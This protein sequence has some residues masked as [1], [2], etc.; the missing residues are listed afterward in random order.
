M[1][2]FEHQVHVAG[3]HVY[4]SDTRHRDLVYDFAIKVNKPSPNGFATLPYDLG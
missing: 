2:L 3:I 4:S 1:V